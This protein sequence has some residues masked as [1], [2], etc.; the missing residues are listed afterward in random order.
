MPL[1][2]KTATLSI[3]ISLYHQWGMAQ[4]G[5]LL[6][7]PALPVGA[8]ADERMGGDPWVARVPAFH[9]NILDT[10]VSGAG[11]DVGLHPENPP[12][13]DHLKGTTS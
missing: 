5:G 9:K 10:R 3:T 1:T 6:W 11:A 4:S 12:F 13:T 2:S 7:S 8:G